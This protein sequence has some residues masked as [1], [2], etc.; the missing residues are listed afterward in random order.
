MNRREASY[1]PSPMARAY[2]PCGWTFRSARRWFVAVS[3]RSHGRDA[4][5]RERLGLQTIAACLVVAITGLALRGQSDKGRPQFW[6]F[7][8]VQRRDP[9]AVHD[10]AWVRN[11][12]DSFVLAKLEQ[13]G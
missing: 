2:R 1:D 6:S 3:R 5:A 4:R 7:T 13:Q 10:P 9:P 11:P 12:I 8:P